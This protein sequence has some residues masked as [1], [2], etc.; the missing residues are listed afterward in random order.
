MSSHFLP[1]TQVRGVVNL[2]EEYRGPTQSYKRLGMRQLWLPTTDHFEPSVEDLESAVNFIAEHEA[3]GK[4]VYVHCRAGHGRS[5]AVVFAW[6]LAKDP[7]T[8]MKKLNQELCQLRD[9]R[10]TLWKQH[11]ILRLH[12]RLL[13]ANPEPADGD[14]D[15]AAG[16]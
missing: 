13:K 16:H 5:A 12:D 3:I 2:C 8:D 9:V 10:R 14:D 15:D 7:K 11:N 6:L 4:R 1:S